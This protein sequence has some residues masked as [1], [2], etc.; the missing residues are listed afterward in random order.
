MAQLKRIKKVSKKV[1]K[2]IAPK[3]GRSKGSSNKEKKWSRA[4]MEYWNKVTKNPAKREKMGLPPLL[5]G[6]KIP[7]LSKSDKDWVKE[8]IEESPK[9]TSLADNF[10]KINSEHQNNQNYSDNEQL[11]IENRKQE[12]KMYERTQRVN[13]IINAV[14]TLST[15]AN[16]I[17]TA[18][19]VLDQTIRYD[20]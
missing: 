15:I 7:K 3:R 1:A 4:N 14:Q 8:V 18:I 5:P 10:D 2:K 11:S 6:G 17:Q 9:V 16:S 13:G 19:N 20:S 12:M